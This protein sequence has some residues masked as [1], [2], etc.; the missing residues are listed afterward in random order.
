MMK[1]TA[2]NYQSEVIESEQPVVIDYY[3]DWCGPCKALAP[4]VEKLAEKHGLKL[5]TIDIDEE[6][7]LAQEAGVQSIPFIKLVRNGQVQA[8]SLGAMPLANLEKRL[9]LSI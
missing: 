9:G 1:V 2:A 4:V 3:A 5:V 6:Q 8:E 7:G